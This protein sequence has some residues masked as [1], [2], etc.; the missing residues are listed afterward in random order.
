[1][2]NAAAATAFLA[3]DN[4]GLLWNILGQHGAFN[5]IESQQ[6]DAIKQHFERTV[7]NVYQQL[8]A[9]NGVTLIDL[10][11]R[12]LS[13]MMQDMAQYRAPA[14]TGSAVTTTTT[15]TAA[16]VDTAAALSAQKQAAFQQG[17]THKQA[18]FSTLM[19]NQA[20]PKIDFA[21][22]AVQ[23]DKPLAGDM[24]RLVKEAM[25]WR[26][27][28]LNLIQAK[29]VVNSVIAAASPASAPLLKIG[30]D[31]QLPLPL[32]LPPTL[33]VRPT[34]KKMVNFV[35]EVLKMDDDKRLADDKR[36]A[37]DK[38]MAIDQRPP[39]DNNTI[40]LTEMLA[41]QKEILATLKI[42]MTEKNLL[43]SKN[44]LAAKSTETATYTTLPTPT[45]SPAIMF[46]E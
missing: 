7:A 5:G 4:K 46:R 29:P 31:I 10:N 33:S 42:L 23:D 9:A 16:V 36:V 28:D 27:K 13:I 1:M 24:D 12:T 25:A 41:I 21:D 44:L 40:L 18:E 43:A 6:G 22:K 11:K 17:L 26:E 35:Q 20:P 14:T 38:R 34:P 8:G 45:P 19:N 15:T 3:N 2:A 39:S 32:T 30:P 37:D